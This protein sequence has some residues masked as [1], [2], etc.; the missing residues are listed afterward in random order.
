[1]ARH[2]GGEWA[3]PPPWWSPLWAPAS[4]NGTLVGA[5]ANLTVAGLAERNG[6][7]SAS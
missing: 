1:M 5:A 6:I 2:R 4:G 7:R 3:V